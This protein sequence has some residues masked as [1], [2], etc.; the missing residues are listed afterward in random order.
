MALV[1][2]TNTVGVNPAGTIPGGFTQRSESVGD[3]GASAWRAV[4]GAGDQLQR[5]GD[6]LSQQVIQ[7]QNLENETQATETVTGFSRALNEQWAAFSELQGTAATAAYPGFVERV[8]GLADSTLA[9]ATNPRVRQMI[10]GRIG[11]MTESMIGGAT[12]WNVRQRR[13]ASVQASEGAAAEAVANGLRDR[14]NPVGV[15]RALEQGLSEV[16]KIGEIAGWDATTLR[17][18][19]A[20]YRGRYYSAIIDTTLANTNDPTRV[21]RAIDIFGRVRGSLDAATQVRIAEQLAPRAIAARA[22]GIVARATTPDSA[23]SVRDRVFRAENPAGDARRNPNSSASGPGQITDGTWAAYAPRLGLRPEQRNDRAAQ[24]AIF[25]A[26]QQDAKREIGRD[27]TDGEQYAA[28]VLGIAGAKAFIMAPRDANAREV[29]GTVTSAANADAAFRNNGALMRP[30]MTTGQVLDALAGRVGNAPARGDHGAMLRAALD[31]AGGDPQLQAA[32][33]S[34]FGMW[35]NV[36]NATQ[37]QDRAAME[38]RVTDIGRAL[39][40]GA[41]TSIPA[42]DIRRL[43]QPEQADRIL[44]DLATRQ[45]AGQ[46]FRSVQ[47]ATPAELQ[48]LREDLQSGNGTVSALLRLRRGTRTDASGAVTEEDRPGDLA[49]RGA[50]ARV[51]DER[52]QERNR[53]RDAD[54]AQFVLADPGVRAAAQAAATGGPDAMAAYVTATTAAQARIGVPDHEQRILSRAQA[55]SIASQIMRTDP[56]AGTAEAPDGPALRLRAL[57]QT[58][59]EAW[60]RVMNDLVR[61]GN[62]SPDYQVLATIPSAVGQADFARMMTAARAA[63]GVPQFREAVRRAAPAEEVRLSREVGEYIAPFVRSATASGQS[64]GDRLAAIVGSSIE[65]LAAYYVTRGSSAGTALQMATDRVLNDKYEFQGTMRVPRTLPNGQPLGLRPVQQAQAH[66]MRNLRP[67]ALADIPGAPDVPEAT[68]RETVWRAAQNGFWAP[69]ERD[70]GLVLMMELQNGGRLPV[71]RMGGERIE[72]LYND[73]PRPVIEGAAAQRDSPA[74]GVT[75]IE[76]FDEPPATGTPP[77]AGAGTQPP[78]QPVLPGDRRGR[79]GTQPRG[80]WMPPQ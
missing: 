62:L 59:G 14:D 22:E 52:I 29:Y 71:R 17:A 13:T 27:L 70:T 75:R 74:R 1:P 72:L 3:M 33:M 58:Y 77:A 43:F 68:R 9:G 54:Q 15:L 67:E 25:D 10:A 32:V 64:G 30:G 20:E 44:D 76:G 11:Q 34:Q 31:Q 60:P 5:T 40:L 80:T 50:M 4:S 53:L 28:W 24:E 26:Y 37:A 69:N 51:L 45:I 16:R 6:A 79:S 73:M 56:A 7:A 21:Q 23:T 55:Q 8:R 47:L 66:I 57:E 35:Q 18:R 49:A 46:V 78:V 19:E 39:D 36:L 2:R 48:T 12:T 38:R 65:N 41:D 63:G 42:A 61:D